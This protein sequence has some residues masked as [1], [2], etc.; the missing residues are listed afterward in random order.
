MSDPAS[1]CNGQCP[2]HR[3]GLNLVRNYPAYKWGILIF[4]MLSLAMA[5]FIALWLRRRF[6]LSRALQHC[7]QMPLQRAILLHGSLPQ[8]FPWT[9]LV[10]LLLTSAAV[11][12]CLKEKKLYKERYFITSFEQMKRIAECMAYGA[13]FLIISFFLLRGSH[14][15]IKQ[16][17][18]L[19]ILFTGLGFILLVLERLV[20][21]RKALSTKWFHYL[22]RKILIV[23]SD[24]LAKTIAATILNNESLSLEVA[25]FWDD[26]KYRAD[27]TI[28]G[29]EVW[30]GSERYGSEG[31]KD[32]VKSK[33]IDE[34]FIAIDNAGYDR[35]LR[36]IDLCKQTGVPVSVLSRQFQ[37]IS[38]KM[39]LAEFKDLQ[40]VVF[41]HST[42]LL[43]SYRMKRMI[44]IILSLLL[45]L[46]LSPLF[47]ILASPH[48]TDLR[49]SRLF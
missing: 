4:D 2:G 5:A 12:V 11:V 41:A 35:I 23:G 10:L 37:V 48:Q 47:S 33:K 34:I 14:L 3:Q 38:D 22:K 8:L 15:E 42:Y 27:K 7:E 20:F 43:R 25:G 18:S 1:P 39:D 6:D 45:L 46:I 36:I 29:Y 19:F 26:E 31:L 28:L 24:S 32:I 13:V 49:R 16:S 30:Y 44:D 9:K 40:S 21:L 17:R